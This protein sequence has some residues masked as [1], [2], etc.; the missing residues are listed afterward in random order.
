MQILDYIVRSAW[1]YLIQID[2]SRVSQLDSSNPKPKK[3]ANL[4]LFIS[5]HFFP[6]A[7]LLLIVPIF[8]SLFVTRGQ[9]KDKATRRQSMK[10][11]HERI[12][13]HCIY[14]NKTS[15]NTLLSYFLSFQK[16][17]AGRDSALV[18][19]A[20]TKTSNVSASA[21]RCTVIS[22]QLLVIFQSFTGFNSF[23]HVFVKDSSMNCV[24]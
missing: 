7:S 17:C 19:V 2:S 18:V 23:E 15:R 8:V 16:L 4:Q 1:I 20:K 5:L 6:F 14:M 11:K 21:P 12:R 9:R 13:I 3:L 10:S 22:S 24:S